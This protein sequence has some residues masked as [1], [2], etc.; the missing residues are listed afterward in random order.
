M[1]WCEIIYSTQ[2]RVISCNLIARDCTLL[3]ILRRGIRTLFCGF[4]GNHAHKPE[5]L[6]S[7]TEGEVNQALKEAIIHGDLN[8]AEDALRACEMIGVS[9]V[10]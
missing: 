10:C 7:Q 6:V 1:D 5:W 3:S 8:R 2:Q 9:L 4:V